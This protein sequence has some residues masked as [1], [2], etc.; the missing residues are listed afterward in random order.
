MRQRARFL[1][2]REK[3]EA[4]SISLPDALELKASKLGV[5]LKEMDVQNLIQ[6]NESNPDFLD[7]FR[8]NTEDLL[9]WLED[10]KCKLEDLE[11]DYAKE[12]TH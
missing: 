4:D 12:I 8:A 9:L 7:S 5:R 11:F 10:T 1:K 6:K 3:L 2:D